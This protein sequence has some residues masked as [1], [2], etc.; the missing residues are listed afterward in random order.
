MQMLD[1]HEVH[2]LDTHEVQKLDTHEVHKLDTH[3]VQ[4]LDTHEVHVNKKTFKKALL[5][6]IRVRHPRGANVRHPRGARKQEDLQES[7]SVPYQMLDTHEVHVKQRR[8]SRK[9]F[10]SLS[11]VRHPRGAR[12]TLEDLQESSSV[13]LCKC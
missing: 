13:L 3:E 2:E 4:M 6:L 1:T 11:N 8:P 12:R 9:L 7:S 5:F 10:C